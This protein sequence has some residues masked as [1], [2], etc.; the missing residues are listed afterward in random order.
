MITSDLQSLLQPGLISNDRVYR[1][2]VEILSSMQKSP[3]CNKIATSALLDSCRSIDGSKS[4]AEHQGELLKSVFAAQ[5]AI[6]ELSEAGASVPQ[7]C[8]TL[9]VSSSRLPVNRIKHFHKS[10]VGKCLGALEARP[11]AWISYSNSKQNAVMLCKAA[12]VDIDKGKR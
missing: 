3:T 12:R 8:Q 11:Q 5:L 2:A 6:C 9:A 7:A 1:E 4:D 10:N